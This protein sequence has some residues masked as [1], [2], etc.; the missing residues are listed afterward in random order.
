MNRILQ[1]R[2]QRADSRPLYCVLGVS[3]FYTNHC[4]PV[5]KSGGKNELT[6]MGEAALLE[7]GEVNRKQGDTMMTVPAEAT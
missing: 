2:L 7:G 6:G 5:G 4:I 3:Q 1:V